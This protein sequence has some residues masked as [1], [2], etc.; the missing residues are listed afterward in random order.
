L[1]H[2]IVEEVDVEKARVKI[3]YT[4]WPRTFD[5]WV[6]LGS[7]TIMSGA[8]DLISRYLNGRVLCSDEDTP[9]AVARRFRIDE[10]SLCALNQMEY[11][12]LMPASR[13][14]KG[15]FLM[16]PVPYHILN[17]T[18]NARESGED[19]D[20]DD[21]DND[22]DE[23]Q[24]LEHEQAGTQGGSHAV[25]RKRHAGDRGALRFGHMAVL[26]G[27]KQEALGARVV[28]NCLDARHIGRVWGY[29][30]L[31][32]KYLIKLDHAVGPLGESLEAGEV[33]SPIPCEHVMIVER[34]LDE[35]RSESVQRRVLTAEQ[36]RAVRSLPPWH[37]VLTEKN[38]SSFPQTCAILYIIMHALAV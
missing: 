19:G 1:Y 23:H 21:E 4:R 30:V 33:Y 34:V 32:N 26:A 38:V 8:S 10:M 14:R 25:L 36:R 29:H 22:D 7:T 18:R 35:P 27:A 17:R 3:H 37:L 5:R 15:T 16:L 28:I 13:L 6:A 20:T 24:E 2:G 9:R 11:P 31:T 12:D